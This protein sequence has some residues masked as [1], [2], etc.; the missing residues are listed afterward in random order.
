MDFP[1][2]LVRVEKT[3]KLALNVSSL[4]IYGGKP[5]IVPKNKMQ[6]LG[7]F[8]LTYERHYTIQEIE[9]ELAKMGIK[10]ANAYRELRTREVEFDKPYR[11]MQTTDFRAYNIPEKLANKEREKAIALARSCTS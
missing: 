6:R 3:D 5:I 2:E 10:N 4:P 9:A 8:N 1:V 7:F 11:V